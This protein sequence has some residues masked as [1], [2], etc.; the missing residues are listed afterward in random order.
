MQEELI[1]ET[2]ANCE[3]VNK[4]SVLTEEK[5]SLERILMQQQKHYRKWLQ[6]P[7]LSWD[8]DIEKLTAIDKEQKELITV[9]NNQLTQSLP[10]SQILCNRCFFMSKAFGTRNS[11]FTG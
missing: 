4:L 7:N 10:K 6:P 5:N 9:I 1:K 11:Y 8:R 3:K 2:R